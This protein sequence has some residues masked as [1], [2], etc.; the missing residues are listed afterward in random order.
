MLVN[1]EEEQQAVSSWSLLVSRP[2]V[3]AEAVVLIGQ[4]GVV[5]QVWHRGLQLD[6]NWQ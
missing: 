6:D 4:G 1:T 3:G 5:P 2:R